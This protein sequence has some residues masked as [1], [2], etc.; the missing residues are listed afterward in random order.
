MWSPLF[1]SIRLIALTATSFLFGS[2]PVVAQQYISVRVQINRMPD[3]HFPTK[4]YQFTSTPGLVTLTLTNLTNSTQNIYLTGKLTGDNGVLVVTSKNYQPPTTIELAPLSTKTLNAI[5]AS[6]L[7]DANNLTYISGNTSIKSSVFGEQGLPEGTY[8]L[9]VRA[10]DAA[11]RQPLSDDEPIG[12]SNLFQVSLLEPP[13]ILNPF[14]DQVLDTIGIQNFP[15]R[16]TTPPGAPPSIE[17]YLRIIEIFGQQNPYDAMFSSPVP[18]FETTVK[19]APVFL[20]SVQQPQ[21][22]KGRAYAMVVIASDPFG[23]SSFRNKGQSELVKF[24]YGSKNGAVGESVQTP[25]MKFSNEYADHKISGHLSWAFK[26]SEKGTFT[27]STGSGLE[28]HK[29]EPLLALGTEKK[30]VA[31]S[32]KS[33][34]A[35]PYIAATISPNAYALQ[36][37]ITPMIGFNAVAAV[38]TDPSL[39]THSSGTIY[40]DLNHHG[41]ISDQGPPVGFVS[42]SGADRVSAIYEPIGEDTAKERYPLS[43]VSLMLH[44]YKNSGQTIL[45]G[46][47]KTD[48]DGNFS[49]EFLDPSYA[50]AE[51]ITRLTLSA[52]TT[53]FENTVYDVSLSVLNKADADIGIHTLLAKT[54]RLV[55]KIVPNQNMPMKDARFE[56]HIYRDARDLESRPWLA[57][58][59]VAGES[60]APAGEIIDGRLEIASGE[61]LAQTPDPVTTFRIIKETIVGQGAGRIFFGGNIYISLLPAS[62]NYY[63]LHSVVNAVNIPLPSGKVVSANLEY[64]F[65]QQ[66]SHISGNVALPLGD[67]GPI[68]IAG[69]L[70]RVL[71]EIKDRAPGRDFNDVFSTVAKEKNN[72]SVIGQPEEPGWTSANIHDP[73]VTTLQALAYGISNTG[74]STALIVEARSVAGSSASQ[75]TVKAVLDPVIAVSEVNVVPEGFKSVTTTVDASG[76]YYITLP[77]L[78]DGAHIKVEVIKTPAEFRKFAIKVKGEEQPTASITLVKGSSRIVDFQLMGDVAEIMGRVVDDQGSPLQNATINFRGNVIG[79]T[80][81]EGIFNTMI[82]PGSH[83]FRLEK[84]GYVA[85]DIIV[86]VPQLT[87]STEKSYGERWLKMTAV[88]KNAATLA[89]VSS[90]PTV[91]AAI[92]KGDVFSPAMFGIAASATGSESMAAGTFNP[93]L[94]N[95]FYSISSGSTYET[96]REFAIDLKDVGYLPKIVGK[97]RFRIVDAGNNVPVAGVRLTLFDSTNT[98]DENGEWYYEGFGGSAMLTLIPPA[99]AAYIAAQKLITLSESGR[100]ELIVV[101]LE[102]GILISGTVT[103]AGKPLPAARILLDDQDF[104]GITTDA[105]GHYQFYTSPGAHKVS[106]RKKGFV[107]DDKSPGDLNEINTIDFQLTGGNGN[108][109]YATLLGFDIELDHAIPSGAGQEKWSGNFVNFQSVNPEIFV[110]SGEKRIP[111]S[112]LIV[113]FDAGGL[114]LPQGNKVTTDITELPLKIFGYLPANLKTAEVISFSGTSGGKGQLSGSIIVAFNSI[115]GYRGWK[116]NEKVQMELAQ[117]GSSQRDKFVVLS[118]EGG[119]PGSSQFALVTET[120]VSATAKVYGFD[121]NLS[122]GKADIDGITFSGTVATPELTTI[123]SISFGMKSLS[124]N[125]VLTVSGVILNDES[126]PVLEIA[127]WKASLDN[128]IFDEDGFRLGG[129]MNLNLLKSTGSILDFS[130]LSISRDQVFGGNFNL[131]SAGINLLTLA[132]LKADGASL[133]FGRIGSSNIYRVTGKAL[134]KVNVSILDRPFKVPSFEIMTNGSFN[135]QV[136]AN[137]WIPV[138]LF[139]FTISNLLIDAKARIPSIT[140]QGQFK[141]DL[142]FISFETG[143]IVITAGGSGP[144]FSVNK[145]GVRLDV[146]LLTTSALVSFSDEGFEGSGE[147]TIKGAEVIGGSVLFKYFKRSNGVELGAKFFAN[148]PSIPLGPYFTLDGIG[149]G[150]DYRPGPQKENGGFDVEISA[151]ISVL[152]AKGV[153]AATVNPLTIKVESAGI[154]TGSGDVLM[155]NII[156][157]SNAIVKFNGPE[158]TFSIEINTTASPLEGLANEKVYGTLVLCANKGDEFVFLGSGYHTTLLG[159]IDN[160]GNLAIG[161]H[162]KNPKGRG[163]LIAEYFKDAPDD[164]MV[165][166]FSGVYIN[167]AAR[168]GVLEEDAIGINFG[169]ASASAWFGYQ[170]SGNLLLN[171]EENA[172]R[173]SLMG[174]VEL[175]VKGCLLEA[176]AGAKGRVCLRADGGYNAAQGWNF[177]AFACGGVEFHVEVNC[178]EAGCNALDGPLDCAGAAVKICGTATLKIGFTNGKLNMDASAG[179]ELTS[180][181]K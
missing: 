49:I 48:K 3:G 117:V 181:A 71:Y 59:G 40:Q 85:R 142:P 163:G 114:A 168:L 102:K 119:K 150:F 84:E 137:Y 135:V 104:S 132:D 18:F 172:Y 97:A 67:K 128:I 127:A 180:C 69:A 1:F 39:Q 63:D 51:N 72:L 70:V 112:N 86:T 122:D 35:S 111:F 161:M 60:S 121:V 147:L 164:Y 131:P 107:G 30:A 62:A 73:G 8:Q 174:D 152:G 113:S 96:P 165:E 170:Y 47:G 178:R 77:P 115:Q 89:R 68:Y 56:Y 106:A 32:D 78:V 19:G 42:A 109:N 133:S 160:V 173:L 12:C 138:K 144:E 146:P 29:N 169:F 4:I 27:I 15:L 123:Q 6:Y 50:S 66:P 110:L 177:S 80:G 87:N 36:T 143:D 26:K 162:V 46:T 81:K 58:E 91:K 45:F 53:D 16:W 57:N 20:Y 156:N 129:S 126:K 21:M 140:V 17:Y 54:L 41:A 5:E 92:Q 11:S 139:N 171:F 44:G 22:Q 25:P 167:V 23:N 65:S 159:L 108:R 125:K 9:C 13:M 28:L 2:F 148:I 82:Y 34:A 64:K 101:K 154:L 136:P 153:A 116:I 149:G 130:D 79:K 55:P 99:G 105:S 88:E 158:K 179:G 124:I 120:G 61:V 76:S 103:G 24:T 83:S 52:T 75:N 33:V 98:T 93:L 7:F 90:S 43:G 166:R 74:L 151:K 176:C 95:A 100:E 118:S 134:F 37:A 94:V 145:V 157:T 155:A 38:N 175:G 141:A 14:D 10:I 31:I